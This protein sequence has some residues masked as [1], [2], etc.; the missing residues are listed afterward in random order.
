MIRHSRIEEISL[1]PGAEK[2][3]KVWYCPEPEEVRSLW[4]T[5]RRRLSLESTSLEYRG[6]PVDRL[7]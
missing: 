7:T 3:I 1:G 4:E 6:T 5:Y 2:T